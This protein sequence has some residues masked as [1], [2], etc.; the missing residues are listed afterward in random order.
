MTIGA[1]Q[2]AASAVS[3]GLWWTAASATNVA[4]AGVERAVGQDAPQVTRVQLAERPGGGVTA[5]GTSAPGDAVP[6][7]DP[8]SP[9]ADAQGYVQRPGIQSPA[10]L[11]EM[12]I[13]SAF[14]AANVVTLRTASEA[15]LSAAKLGVEQTERS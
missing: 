8:E 7:H 15:Y 2:S 14:V 10:E 5:T 12:L 4:N 11:A 1:M 13:A 9:L 6:V 3:A